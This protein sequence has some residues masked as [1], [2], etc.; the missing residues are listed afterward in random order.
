MKAEP[1]PVWLLTG[2]LGAGK[3]SLLRQWLRAPEL[4]NAAL[5]IN[6]FGEVGLDD[7]LLGAA[8]DSPAL[9]SGACVCCSGLE[10][11]EG[12]LSDLFW[13]RLHRRRPRF[14]AVV[15]ET[16][17][18]AD[19]RPI[20]RALA[21]HPLLRERY[22]LRATLSVVSSTNGAQT[23]AQFDE[24]RAQLAAADLAIITKTDLAPAEPTLEAFGRVNPQVLCLQSA[25]ASV[26]WQ[27]VQQACAAPGAVPAADAAAAHLHTAEA[28]FI[29]MPQTLDEADLQN[30]LNAL[31]RPDAL[32]FKG[33]I[34]VHGRGLT[35]VQWAWLDAEV[36]LLPF[37]ET[38]P[39]RLGITCIRRQ[40]RSEHAH[41]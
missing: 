34:N 9:I 36:Q 27:Q 7:A 35:T 23:L 25:Q 18:L 26:S 4:A 33:V 29:P 39:P 19:P 32:R 38:A 1:I 37:A 41:A 21:Q 22:A 8:V 6:E 13:D 12:T 16:T 2:F 28:E 10:G 24:A 20:Q 15:I 3:T 30:H 5:V 31:Q 17:G 11:L 14:D 40:T